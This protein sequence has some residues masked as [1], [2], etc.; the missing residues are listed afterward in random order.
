MSALSFDDALLV[1]IAGGVGTL[2]G[3]AITAAVAYRTKLLEFRVS[4]ALE[5]TAARRRQGERQ[6]EIAQQLLT[7]LTDLQA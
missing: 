2:V 7:A 4:A 5:Q 1:A 6:A 3:G